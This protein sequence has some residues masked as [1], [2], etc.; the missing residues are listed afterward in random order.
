MDAF[1]HKLK[2]PHAAKATYTMLYTQKW[3]PHGNDKDTSKGDSKNI[4]RHPQYTLKKHYHIKANTSKGRGGMRV[5]LSV[6]KKTP[7]FLR[8]SLHTGREYAHTH[9]ARLIEHLR[10]LYQYSLLVLW[11]G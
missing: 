10:K 7:G 6:T 1:R 9:Y 11:F 5:A 4:L 3:I 8:G 2:D